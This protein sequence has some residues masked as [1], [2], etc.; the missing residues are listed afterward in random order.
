MIAGLSDPEMRQLIQTHRCGC[1]KRLI[2]CWG[3]HYG[4][5]A[6]V[7]RCAMRRDHTETQRIPR[8]RKLYDPDT[9]SFIEVD[10]MTQKPVGQVLAV[11]TTREGMIERVNHAQQAG[12][13]PSQMTRE[14]KAMMVQAALA[15][16]VDPLLGEIILY[17]GRPYITINA[18][19]RKDAEAGHR[20]TIT[21]RIPTTEEQAALERAGIFQEGDLYQCCTLATEWGNSVQAWGKV[22]K[23]ERTNGRS[24]VATS[25]PLEMAQKRAEARARLMAYGPTPLPDI[26]GLAVGEI[27]EDVP[28]VIIEGESHELPDT[29]E[30]SHSLPEGDDAR[31]DDIEMQWRDM[32][33]S[34]RERHSH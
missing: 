15:Y 31:P 27:A 17:Q 30:E 9:K 26:P 7:V 11:P 8:T 23:L 34:T 10:V 29:P 12:L 28:D 20:P 32:E 19:R 33:Q 21:F 14:Q 4:V 18:R 24:P 25:Y 1:G 5:N 16:G 2:M 6:Y 3:G 13:W 22:T